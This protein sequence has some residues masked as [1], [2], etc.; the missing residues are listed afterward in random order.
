MNIDVIQPNRDWLH[1][2]TSTATKRSDN[3]DLFSAAS[4]VKNRER[5]EE[6]CRVS[7]RMEPDS[8]AKQSGERITM[9]ESELGRKEPEASKEQPVKKEVAENSHQMEGQQEQGG[10]SCSQSTGHSPQEPAKVGTV[11]NKYRTVADM[12]TDAGV[13]GVL[14]KRLLGA[15]NKNKLKLVDALMIES[16]RPGMLTL[17]EC[18]EP[19]YFKCVL[20][21]EHDPLFSRREFAPARRSQQEAPK[22]AVTLQTSMETEKATVEEAVSKQ[23]RKDNEIERRRGRRMSRVTS[24]VAM[25]RGLDLLPVPFVLVHRG[26]R[27]T[28]RVIKKVDST[29]QKS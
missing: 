8:E 7:N 11:G 13:G 21:E 25:S 27:R 28:K 1:C 16:G 9:P 24:T 10:T 22:E 5:V 26:A 17:V 6:F 15:V 4:E 23:K 3:F 20:L 12:V 2:S 29:M 14:H 19:P 18:E